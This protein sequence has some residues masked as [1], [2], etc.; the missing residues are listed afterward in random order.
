MSVFS[1]KPDSVRPYGNVLIGSGEK[2]RQYSGEITTIMGELDGSL[3]EVKPSLEVL[4]NQ[5]MEESNALSKLGDALT[6]I[7]AEYTG[8]ESNI[9]GNMN[10]SGG[11]GYD[12]HDDN[13]AQD[14]QSD[15]YDDK[16]QYGGNQ[17]AFKNRND[18]H[19]WWFLRWGKDCDLYDFI[20]QHPGYADMTNEEIE[21]LLDTFADN[22][23]GLVAETNMIFAEFE[24]R[25]EEFEKAFGFPM[26]N[27]KGEL[28][29]E[30]LA[31]D[32]F[33]STKDKF[34]IG[35]DD[36]QGLNALS[37]SIYN[38]YR[39]NPDE[40]KK[41]YGFDYFDSDGNVTS[42]AWNTVLDERDAMAE[43]ARRNQRDYVIYRKDEVGSTPDET[44]NKTN[45]YLRDRG[46]N[47]Y[48]ATSVK[49]ASP[50]SIK[51]ELENGKTPIIAAREFN[52]YDEN[53][54]KIN[55]KLIGDHAM[56]IT[57][58]TDDGKYIVSFWGRRCILD[59]NE[60]TSDGN[61]I[62]KTLYVTDIYDEGRMRDGNNEL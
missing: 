27:K 18:V 28:N 55:K 16:G 5:T 37:D 54:V 17:D 20:R 48:T 2:L 60:T 33:L 59:P 15:L 47:S 10:G 8:A 53:G 32:Y 25:Q 52:L 4:A 26:Y 6:R 3:E 1:I 61:S 22:G 62:I 13:G 42:D 12:I 40:F 7:V 39:R 35:P 11:D 14:G 45:R 24:G 31:M 38:Y 43:D 30:M 44:I 29:Y 41:R 36:Q 50:S 46:I 9:M 19:E 51:K 58:V 23:C 49:G 21:A 56:V 57:G 34:Y